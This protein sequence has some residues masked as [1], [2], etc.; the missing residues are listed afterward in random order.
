MKKQISVNLDKDAY[1]A[2]K[3]LCYSENR[4]MSNMLKRALLF[5]W[6]HKEDSPLHDIQ[7][8]EQD[9]ARIEKTGK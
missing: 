4:N 8:F 9:L 2:L 6:E 5:Y 1:Y 3:T 7:S